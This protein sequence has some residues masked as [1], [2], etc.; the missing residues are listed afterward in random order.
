[1]TSAKNFFFLS[2]VLV[3]LSIA[4]TTLLVRAQDSLSPPN[5]QAQERHLQNL[6]QL[7]FGGQNAEAYFSADGNRII[8]Q[9]TRP[10]YQC[11]QIFSMNLD[12]SNVKLLNTGKG[13]TTCGFFF[14][15]G[16]RIIYASTHLTSAI[17]PPAP[18]RSQGYV[19]PIYPSYEIF[20]ANIDGSGLKRL[21]KNPG[22]DAEGTI[23]P[24]GK[25]IVFTSMRGGD[26][27]IYTMN[28]DCSGVK[29]LT[30]EKGYNGGPFFSWDGRTIVYRAYHPKSKE[31]MTEYEALLKQNLIKPTRAEIYMMA[32]DGSN[33]RQ[34]T[35]NGAANWAPF[36]NPN[37]RQIIFSSNLHDPERKSFSLYIINIDGTGLER[38]SYDARFDSIPMFSRDGKKLVFA[39]TRNGKEPR[40]F[41]IFIAD[42]I[43]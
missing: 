43:Q 14:P 42:W 32:S 13:R 3:G 18:D 5:R 39:S 25:K 28:A 12:G 16:K 1:M 7:T 6:K 19:W 41:N 31:E 2:C 10:P 40:E 36:L 27:D 37:N 11:D 17:C 8:F 33:K 20:S 29:Q 9:S 26:L 35:N 21:T 23:S 30:H 24:D 4:F 38:L 34:I 15:D 22:Y